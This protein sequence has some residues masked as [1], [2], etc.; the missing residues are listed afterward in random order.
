MLNENT[1][2]IILKFSILVLLGNLFQ[3]L[4]SIVDKIIVGQFVGT[5][6]FRIVGAAMPIFNM[7]MG[8]C[9]GMSAGIGI[10]VAQFFGAKEEKNASSLSFIRNYHIILMSK[11]RLY[12]G[13]Y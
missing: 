8:I 9:I 6:V 11:R 2:K 10:I 7:F 5:S 12:Y 13:Y 4:Y 3:Q 1:I